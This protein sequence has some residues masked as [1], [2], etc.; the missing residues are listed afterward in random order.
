[1]QAIKGVFPFVIHYTKMA[2]G[3]S[4]DPRLSVPIVGELPA[5]ALGRAGGER[6]EG[7]AKSQGPVV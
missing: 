3:G 1:M 4:W 2:L 5:D 7:N 6:D